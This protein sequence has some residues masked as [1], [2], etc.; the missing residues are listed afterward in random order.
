MPARAVTWTVEARN[1]ATDSDNKIHDDEVARRYGFAGGL[2]PGV[3]TYAWLV[4]QA[5]VSLGPQ[6]VERGTIEA[7]FL[8]PLYDGDKVRVEA[9]PAGAGDPA[10]GLTALRPDGEV[11][12]VGTATLPA[13]A[14][15]PPDL[16]A[17]P[18]AELPDRTA[19]VS[20][21]VLRGLGPLGT[22]EADFR[23]DDAD[24]YHTSVGDDHP[25]W[26][27]AGVAHPG[28]L[29]LFANWALAANVQLGPWIHTGSAATFYRPLYDGE[30]LELR[31]RVADV[32]ERKG[33][34]LVDLDLLYVVAGRAVQRVRHTAIYRVRPA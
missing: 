22:L 28:W 6:W 10:V 24:G 20:S 5:L 19:P 34:E 33:H 15:V 23:A 3:T 16:D 14:H 25:H 8:K 29:L 30:R 9:A 21:E 13:A 2:V 4:R 31:G 12:A 32:Y 11:A 27:E 26:R 7:R 18:P 1:T 17:Y